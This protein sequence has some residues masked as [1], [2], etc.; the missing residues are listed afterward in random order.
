MKAP[1]LP[2]KS[3]DIFNG[4]C[5]SCCYA[6]KGREC[7]RGS[8]EDF[9]ESPASPAP[10]VVSSDLPLEDDRERYRT[11]AAQ[12]IPD[13]PHPENDNPQGDRAAG[14]SLSADGT[15]S[16]DPRHKIQDQVFNFA[17]RARKLPLEKRQAVPGLVESLLSTETLELD[18][19]DMV[20]RVRELP[21]E[22]R[23]QTTEMMLQIL[24]AMLA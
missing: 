9:Q 10:A 3:Q 7:D 1:T 4:S 8:A 5:P 21:R 23:A 22:E 13:P 19:L 2:G 24:R 20:R 17:C 15:D 11:R 18:A 14:E 16:Q 6:G 12:R